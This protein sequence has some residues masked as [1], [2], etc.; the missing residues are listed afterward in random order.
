MSS[1]SKTP[2]SAESGAPVTLPNQRSQLVL[3]GV[4]PALLEM[5]ARLE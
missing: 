3:S 2:G 5:A 4:T 1:P